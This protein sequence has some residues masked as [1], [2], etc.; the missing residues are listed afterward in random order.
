ML[1][2]RVV[3]VWDRAENQL[4]ATAEQV[5]GRQPP[6][7]WQP[8]GRHL[9]TV[10]ALE[11][12]GPWVVLHERNG[13]QHG[14]FDLQLPAEAA[15]GEGAR[16]VQVLLRGKHTNQLV[17]ATPPSLLQIPLLASRPFVLAHPLAGFTVDALAWSAD[18]ELLAVVLGPAPADDAAGRG[19]WML[20]VDHR[21][22]RT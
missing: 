21:G 15:A 13:L 1:M 11:G 6:M 3:Q 16:A 19:V 9:Y 22:S 7:A 4:H 12:A 20:Q 14:A 2:R 5:P 8:N 18:S 17:L 10:A